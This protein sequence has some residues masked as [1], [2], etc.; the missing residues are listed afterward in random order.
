[1][2][3]QCKRSNHRLPFIALGAVL[4]WAVGARAADVL[5]L[6]GNAKVPVLGA[7]TIVREPTRGPV[8]LELDFFDSGAKTLVVNGCEPTGSRCLP[9]IAATAPLM[10][11]KALRKLESQH[12]SKGF[13][14]TRLT[15]DPGHLAGTFFDAF[16]GTPHYSLQL[17][18]Q[19]PSLGGLG[20]DALNSLAAFAKQQAELNG[21][22]FTCANDDITTNDAC[23]STADK[24]NQKDVTL[25][26]RTFGTVAEPKVCYVEF[27]FGYGATGPAGPVVGPGKPDSNST[28]RL[29]GATTGAGVLVVKGELVVKKAH[30]FT[31]DGLVVVVGPEASAKFLG[32]T[33]IRGGVILGTSEPYCLTSSC[34]TPDLLGWYMNDVVPS[35]SGSIRYYIDR[36]ATAEA[37]LAGWTP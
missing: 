15:G 24:G 28:V 6:V 29:E 32:A 10:F 12:V 11:E 2:S 4:A 14:G 22:A 3:D 5:V 35:G 19:D 36:V 21:C 20:F 30:A 34:P 17:Q 9:G 33:A 16:T 18:P 26:D 27:Q 7:F 23:P 31:Y 1:M 8:S 25:R 37:L 13:F